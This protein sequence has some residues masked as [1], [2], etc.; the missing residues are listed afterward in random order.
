VQFIIGFI[1]H[2]SPLVIYLIV[3]VDLLL[4]SSGVPITN[5]VLLLF[6]GAL[7]SLGHLN[8]WLLTLAAILG[9]IAGAS[10]AY[11]IGAYGGRLMFLRLV[12]FFRIDE[13]KIRM[14]ERWF[15][16]SGVWM[17]FLSRMTPYVRPFAC[18]LGG[19]THIPAG[20][21][22]T[23][24]LTGSMLWCVVMIQV[25]AM[26]GPHWEIAL[27]LVKHYTLPTILA[28]VLLL[29]LYCFIKFMIGRH[30][31]LRQDGAIDVAHEGSEQ[32]NCDLQQV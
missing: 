24:A 29:V 4:E 27:Q 26:L 30:R 1:L 5:N 16:K 17:I 31:H 11:V 14:T 2:A 7:A 25:G 21:F 18:F 32:S 6:T 3:A 9:S 15:H 12:A 10:V 23:A 20:R 28:L 13:S 8:I 19:I 22:F